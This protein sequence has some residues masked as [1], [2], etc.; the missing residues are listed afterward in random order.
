MRVLMVEDEKYLALATRE[1]LK[2]ANYI[3]DLAYDGEEGLELATTGIYDLLIFDIMLPIKSGLDILKA[4]RAEGISTP[5][6]LLTAKGEVEDRVKG[7]DLG[8][9]D[10]LAKP[11]HVKELLARLRALSRRPEVVQIEGL[12]FGDLTL[13]PTDLTLRSG[14]QEVTLTLKESQILGLLIQNGKRIVSKEWII[15]K[16]WGWDSDATDNH[17]ESHISLIRKKLTHVVS[18]V[19][20]KAIRGAGYVLE[21]GGKSNETSL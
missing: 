5:V 4:I 12:T 6:L 8:A 13:N 17:V 14:Q 7:L 3:V 20:V 2:K 11:F 21:D 9:D 1:S 19:K 18:H 16:V 15:E 10:Y